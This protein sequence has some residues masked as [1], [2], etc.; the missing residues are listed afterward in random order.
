MIE[1]ARQ[2]MI[3]AVNAATGRTDCG[4]AVMLIKRP[5]WSY[6]LFVVVFLGLLV[7]L[8]ALNLG[9]VI[10]GAIAGGVAGGAMASLGQHRILGYCD[11]TVV[12][13][14]ASPFSVKATGTVATWSYPVPA[15]V[16][17]GALFHT[18]TIGGET[19]QLA[20]QLDERFRSITGTP[21]AAN[22]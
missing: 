18:A 10:G 21:A 13:L 8:S 6:V 20:K 7:A 3:S 14:S 9:A 2:K 12:L 4:E 16:K 15:E 11:G 22:S 19:Y 1:R 17:K 5:W